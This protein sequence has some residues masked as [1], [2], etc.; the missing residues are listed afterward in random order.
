MKKTVWVC[1]LIAGIICSS[2]FYYAIA[3]GAFDSNHFDMGMIYGYASMILGFSLIF[4]AIK[5]YRDKQLGGSISFGKAFLVGLYVTL[6]ASTVYV[7]SWL[8]YFYNFAP[9]FMEQYTN[10]MVE[11]M[12]ANGKSQEVINAQLA[13]MAP[14]A[15]MYKKPV[16]VV[17]F[18]YMEILP[19]GLILCL[20]AALILKK[21]RKGE[22]QAVVS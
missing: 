1:G 13:E 5:M 17:L 4:V 15:E 9:D 16:F 14:M 7:I 6:I 10:Y 3:S 21:K 18:T 12:K 8:I 19:V 20:V 22:Q 2:W 11:D